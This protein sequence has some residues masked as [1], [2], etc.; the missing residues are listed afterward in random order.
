[1]SQPTTIKKTVLLTGGGR[2]L[3][4]AAAE[5]IAAVDNLEVIVTVRSKSQVESVQAG[6]KQKGFSVRVLPLA[7]DD[8]ASVAAFPNELR[9]NGIESLDVVVL[10]A[11]VM[12][13][14]PERR[15]TKNGFEETLQVNVLSQLM[16]VELLTEFLQRGNNPRIVTLTS[17][18]H[19]PD[20]RGL[21]VDFSFDDPN[22]ESPGAY[23]PDRAY[24]NSKLAV[25]WMTYAL[26]DY[27]KQKQ[28]PI[29]VNAFCPGFVPQ[30]AAH[31]TKSWWTWFLLKFVIPHMSFA[32][33]IDSA[34]EVYK[35]MALDDSFN[36]VDGAGFYTE[37]VAAK[38][39]DESYD[40]E[41]QTRFLEWAVTQ[42]E[43]FLP[44]GQSQLKLI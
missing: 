44:S 39:S 40:K 1:M 13:T 14:S 9:S 23:N 29:K 21:P 17:R 19:F 24:K 10:S 32:T 33:S 37:K 16:L 41:K 26:Q 5:K 38:S 8:F 25:L 20:S 36:D 35:F 18:L 22:L 7:F 27:F 43:K 6:F 28:F 12:Q 4:V 42:Y 2:G 31:S 15:V 34:A 30:T 11:A 3:A